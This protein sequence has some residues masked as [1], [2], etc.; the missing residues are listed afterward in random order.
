M[1]AGGPILDPEMEAMILNPICS[2]SLS[3][4][5]LVL[6]AS[7]T[8]EI[9]VTRNQRSGVLLTIDGQDT[10]TL[11]SDDRIVLQKAPFHAVL[12]SS[13]RE[14]YYRALRTKLNWAEKNSTAGDANA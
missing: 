1:A 3:N 12:I 9:V 10:F 8:L 7:Q 2:Q 11:E 4:R 5:P 14:A 6:S 13:G